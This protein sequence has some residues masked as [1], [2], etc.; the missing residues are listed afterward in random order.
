MPTIKDFK[1]YLQNITNLKITQSDIAKALDTSRSNI[2]HRIKNNSEIKISEVE[3]IAKFSNIAK[4]HEF[5]NDYLKY[6][7]QYAG[8][9]K[10]IEEDCKIC[11]I[12]NS[13]KLSNNDSCHEK[14]KTFY[15]RFNQL[16]KENNLNDYQFSKETGITEA[17][18]EKL[19]IG[20]VLPTLEELNALKAHF[21]VSIDW[22]LYGETPCRNAQSENNTLSAQEI[23]I[24]KQMAQ[25]F[26]V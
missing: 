2:S 17:R 11:N 21:D 7:G 4:I 24:L 15:K 5:M 8:D 3:K 19:G 16:Q 10:E 23:T 6:I 20:K 13:L 25:K 22:L 14:L 1:D 18:I 9:L 26:N 12:K